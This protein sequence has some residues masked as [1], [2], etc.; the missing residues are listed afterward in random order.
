LFVSCC[1]WPRR[2][3]TGTPTSGGPKTVTEKA[4]CTLE[5]LV[6]EDATLATGGAADTEAEPE[7]ARLTRSNRV[8]AWI[9]RAETVLNFL[10]V[11]T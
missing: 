2:S 3:E 8:A 6:T 7:I 11:A 5:L 1:P 10:R 4:F 9:T